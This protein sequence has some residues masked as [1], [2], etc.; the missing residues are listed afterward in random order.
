MNIIEKLKRGE[1]VQVSHIVDRSAEKEY[2]TPKKPESARK[3][4]SMQNI[5]GVQLVA[6]AIEHPLHR[7]LEQ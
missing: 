7:T 3:P 4:L 1:G 5:L 2:V 6:S